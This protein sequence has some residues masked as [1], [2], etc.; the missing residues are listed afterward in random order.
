MLVH[1]VMEAMAPV[2]DAFAA[3]WPDCEIHH[4]LDSSLSADLAADGG[5][6]CEGMI[7]RF[8]MLARYAAEPAAGERRADGILF[9][10]S[11]FGA[12]IEAAAREVRIPVLKPNEAAFEEAL[13]TGPR[14]GLVVTFEPSLPPMLAELRQTMRQMANA[15]EP[16]GIVV[17]GAF[18]ALR[19]GRR[20]EHDA[21][22]AEA[23][24]GLPALDAVVLGQFSMAAAAVSARRV[25]ATPVLT[26][27]ESAVK[28]MRGLLGC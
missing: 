13:R 8:R 7:E 18:A 5:V 17:P 26:T 2:R 14:I 23:V 19:A 3:L 20:D 12:A 4:L 28:K 22:I 10:C 16:T 6:L 15:S 1:A 21:R 24:A 9:T 27:P 11:A 25:T